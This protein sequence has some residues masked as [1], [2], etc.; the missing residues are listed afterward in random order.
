MDGYRLN[1]KN[2]RFYVAYILYFSKKYERCFHETLFI[3]FREGSFKFFKNYFGI[4]IKSFDE[5]LGHPE[6][7]LSV[8]IL[9]SIS[10]SRTESLAVTL[11][12]VKI[13]NYII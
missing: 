5:L 7:K 8:Y 12:Y 2:R 3:D 13:N 10:I 4:S 1:E 6:S 11:R 9:N